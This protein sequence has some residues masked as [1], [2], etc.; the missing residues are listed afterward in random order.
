MNISVLIAT[1]GSEDWRELAWSRAFPSAAAQTDDVQ[2]FHDPEG[3]IASVRNEL[4]QQAK[5]DWLLFLDADDEIAPGYLDAMRATYEQEQPDGGTLLLTPAV[6]YVRK[7][8]PAPPKFWGEC[9]F[10]TGNWIVIGTLVERRLFL[11]VGGFEEYPHG[12]EDWQLWA[13][14]VK[15][16]ARIVKVPDAIY[17][18]H[19]NPKSKHAKL[20]RNRPDYMI[21]YEAA[22]ASVWG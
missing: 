21:H 7:G 15:A 20:Q 11:E 18:A 14:C 1:Y 6:S 4:A 5:G 13:K 16:G 9:S 8:K 17:L 10:T 19:T 22:R 2:V 12:L 3:T